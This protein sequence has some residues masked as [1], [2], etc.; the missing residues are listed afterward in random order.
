[1][2]S[3]DSG[4]CH[5]GCGG[6]TPFHGA[7][8]FLHF[9]LSS[10]RTCG[11]PQSGASCSESHSI[12]TQ[13]YFHS[14]TGPICQKCRARGS[15]TSKRSEA[16]AR[17]LSSTAVAG[18]K[19]S[20]R[21]KCSRANFWPTCKPPPSSPKRIVRFHAGRWT[22]MTAAL[23]PCGCNAISGLTPRPYS[24]AQISLGLAQETCITIFAMPL[25]HVPVLLIQET[26]TGQLATLAPLS[27]FSS[28]LTRNAHFEISM[29]YIHKGHQKI[30][31]TPRGGGFSLQMDGI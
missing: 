17:P 1:M 21:E 16:V 27:P 20:D 7:F 8:I 26:C 24:R 3:L 25:S 30:R 29:F 11:T 19:N 5:R 23:S 15:S 6:T 28:R 13:S 14:R 31:R 4:W 18:E 10:S 12:L 9:F 22:R 2:A